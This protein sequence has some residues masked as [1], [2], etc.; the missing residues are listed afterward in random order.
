MVKFTA[1][2]REFS[3]LQNLQTGYEDHP[4]TSVPGTLNPGVKRPGLQTDHSP[5]PGA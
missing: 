2:S 4:D 1:G 3:N 5:P